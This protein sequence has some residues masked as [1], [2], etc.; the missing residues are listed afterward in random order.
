MRRRR[1]LMYAEQRVRVGQR[2][3]AT[4][5]ARV[6]RGW[7]RSPAVSRSTAK[8]RASIGARLTHVAP[9]G[10]ARTRRA[11]AV[12]SWRTRCCRPTTCR[13]MSMSSAGSR[14]QS[15]SGSHSVGGAV[16]GATSNRRS[17]P[18]RASASLRVDLLGP[19]HE[20]DGHRA[21]GDER[22][23]AA[24]RCSG[25]H[26]GS[27][28]PA[29]CRGRGRPAGDVGERWS[30]P[31]DALRHRSTGAGRY[32]ATPGPS[33][34]TSRAVSWSVARRVRTRLLGLRD[35]CVAR[36]W[37]DSVS[38]LIGCEVSAGACAHAALGPHRGAGGGDRPGPIATPPTPTPTTASASRSSTRPTKR[39]HCRSPDDTPRG[40]NRQLHLCRLL[41]S[42]CTAHVICVTDGDAPARRRRVPTSSLTGSDGQIASS[43]SSP[44]RTRMSR[45]TGT[46]RSC[47]RRSCRCGRW[48]VS[49]SISLSTLSLSTSTS[50]FT[51]GTNSTLYSEPRN[52]SVLPPWRP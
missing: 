16:C 35:C 50:I 21:R 3:R 18:A 1:R 5:S 51:L 8:I 10:A 32:R 46:T 42:C 27:S 23:G 12:G 25:Q 44:V 30:A 20:L 19:V 28:S 24:W 45:S 6:V 4:R 29:C 13:Q 9:V 49:A 36:R 47:R 7:T 52:V 41:P 43:P 48:R 33:R 37:I 40:P 15:I 17:C 31:G 11:S 14:I 22:V 38:T 39:A 34:P 2:G 26:R